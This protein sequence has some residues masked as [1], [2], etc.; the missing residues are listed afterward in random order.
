MGTIIDSFSPAFKALVEQG[1]AEEVYVKKNHKR[2]KFVAI[3]GEG[4]RSEVLDVDI[5]LEKW[6]DDTEYEVVIYLEPDFSEVE[7]DH[8]KILD[9]CKIPDP[10]FLKHCKG[11]IVPTQHLKNNIDTHL[12]IDVIKHGF[13]IKKQRKKHHTKLN[14]RVAIFNKITPEMKKI[15]DYDLLK[16]QT[17]NRRILGEYAFAI[18]RGKEYDNIDT[19]NCYMQGIPVAKT[20]DQ[21]QIFCKPKK[22]KETM[23]K[24]SLKNYNI[25]DKSWEYYNLAKYYKET[26]G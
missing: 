8:I 20:D 6:R 15:L 24:I 22:R 23:E 18:I 11:I 12:R 3:K 14:N 13:E 17:V 1:E 16:P 26:Y 25:Y 2:K 5:R 9:T 10:L 4:K 21:V 7:E 19:I